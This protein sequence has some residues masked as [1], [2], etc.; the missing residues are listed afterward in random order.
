MKARKKLPVRWPSRSQTP[1]NRFRSSF[2][3]NEERLRSSCHLVSQS[4]ALFCWQAMTWPWHF[5]DDTT[6]ALTLS[7]RCTATIVPLLLDNSH[8]HSVRASW[9][10]NEQLFEWINGND[11][12]LQPQLTC[13][14]KM[15]F[16]RPRFSKQPNRLSPIIKFDNMIQASQYVCLYVLI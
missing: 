3:H 5:S 11:G 15:H 7:R 1:A 6:N 12:S 2:S 4:G 10:W 9:Q 16:T 14:Y 8:L 13:A